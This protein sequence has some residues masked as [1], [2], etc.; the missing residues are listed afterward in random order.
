MDEQ[1]HGNDMMSNIQV[2]DVVVMKPK[3]YGPEH[4]DQWAGITGIVLEMVANRGV[5]ILVQHPEEPA[6]IPVFAFLSD[7][8]KLVDPDPEYCE[9]CECTPCDCN[10]G[11]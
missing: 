11:I 3:Y 5:S 8:K 6:P 2:G 7:V 1:K 4:V 9:Y 10:W